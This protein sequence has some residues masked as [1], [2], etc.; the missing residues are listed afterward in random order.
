MSSTSPPTIIDPQLLKPKSSVFETEWH[1][2]VKSNFNIHRGIVEWF[3][4]EDFASI[5]DLAARVRR[6]VKQEFQPGWFRGFGFGTV[7]HMRTL[8]P[9]FAQ[10]GK[11]VDTRN[12]D[13]SVWQWAILRF[14]DDRVA[15]G[16]H[17]WLHGYLRPV[18]DSLLGD[19]EGSG[20][21]CCSTD[22]NMDELLAALHRIRQLKNPLTLLSWLDART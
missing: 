15:I 14:D 11:H 13:N 7:L 3:V 9:D 8:S 12:R 6:G 2:W 22:T 19:L 1:L 16:V 5:D 18:Y 20:Y 21:S 17:T 10:I 4:N